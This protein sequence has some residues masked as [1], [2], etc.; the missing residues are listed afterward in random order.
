VLV[1]VVIGFVQYLDRRL[2]PILDECYRLE[3]EDARRSIRL[4]QTAL[5]ERNTVRQNRTFKFRNVDELE[6]LQ[7]VFWRVAAQLKA[8]FDDLELRV[9][10]RTAQLDEA[11]QSAENA[12]DVAIVANRSKSQFL[13]NMSHELRTPLNAILGFAQIMS[14]DSSLKK[15]QQENLSIIG[16]SGEHLLALINDVLDMSKIESGQIGINADDFDLHYLLDSVKEMLEQ[17][18][19]TKGLQLVFTCADELP[20]YIGTDKKKLSQVLLNLLGNAVKFTKSGFVSLQVDLDDRAESK[21]DL[22]IHLR[23]AIEDSGPGIAPNEMNLLFEPFVQT[24]SG[25]KSEEGTG[26]G[27]SI[28]RKFVELMGGTLQASSTFGQGTRFEFAIPVRLSA[29][30]PLVRQQVRRVTGLVNP[31]PIHRILVV[32]DHWEN[33]RLLV[34][35]LEPVGFEVKEAANGQEAIACWQTWK[36]HLIWMDMR[37]P[38]LNGFEATQRIKA[39]LQGQATIVI[40]L[41]ASAL[42]EEIPVIRSA[43]CD[44]FVRKPFLECEIFDKIGQYLNVQY[45]YRTLTVNPPEPVISL[46]QEALAVMPQSWLADLSQASAKL[47]METIADLIGQIPEEHIALRQSIQAK[48]D[49]FDFDHIVLGVQ[50]V[51]TL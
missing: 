10:E 6:I 49:N 42:Y 29:A 25:R 17:R 21:T 3:A 8:S 38:V 34:K 40:A 12:K 9:A 18:A 24:E 28:S 44:D 31:H 16:R 19:K 35:L 39:H 11:K 7:K 45:T 50:Q 48:V 51:R 22:S 27:L 4:G 23:F 1:L 32:D 2:K 47:D 14:R 36:P 20:Q 46:T 33:R 37:M 13:A 26:L 15:E 43:G 30:V 5:E 41:T